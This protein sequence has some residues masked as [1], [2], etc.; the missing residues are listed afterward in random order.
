MQTADEGVRGCLDFVRS[1]D[2]ELSLTALVDSNDDALDGILQ[3][4]EEGLNFLDGQGAVRFEDHVH[5]RGL[6]AGHAARQLDR[7]RR[8]ESTGWVGVKVGAG[9]RGS[10][11]CATGGRSEGDTLAAETDDTDEVFDEV[12][13]VAG[14]AG[15]AG[16]IEGG[17][18]VNASGCRREGDSH[19]SSGDSDGVVQIKVNAEAGLATGKKGDGKRGRR[20]LRLAGDARAY[21]A[22][23]SDN[24]SARSRRS[25][26]N[27][28]AGVVE[29]SDLR[30]AKR[31][32]DAAVGTGCN[33]EQ[34]SD[35]GRIT[36]QTHQVE[37]ERWTRCEGKGS[38]GRRSESD[39]RDGDLV[40][41]EGRASR[42]SI[43]DQSKAHGSCSPAAGY[44]RFWQAAAGGEGNGSEQENQEQCFAAI[45]VVPHTKLICD[46]HAE[47]MKTQQPPG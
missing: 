18:D 11:K 9:C 27:R 1:D 17:Q 31:E 2:G 23:G 33:I 32:R 43:G 16:Q 6:I 35:E 24:A 8:A 12:E 5:A 47:E 14:K 7:S 39:L 42:R 46:C 30:A 22:D 19:G 3:G 45:H 41:E 40:R 20:D 15:V 25:I 37:D 28:G 44:R 34:S 4:R 38:P 36:L 13:L 21:C 26:G 10:R 29:K